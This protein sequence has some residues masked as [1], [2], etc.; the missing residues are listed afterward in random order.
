[1]TNDPY[2]LPDPVATA[3]IY[4]ADRLDHVI[5]HCVAPFW[6]AV[7]ERDG[8]EHAYLWMMRYRRGGEH[9]KVRIHAPDPMGPVLRTELEQAARSYLDTLEGAATDGRDS[10][11]PAVPPVDVEDEVTEPYPDRS[12]LWTRYRRSPVSFGAE[13][14]L[15][16][17]RFAAIFTRAMSHG[18]ARVMAAMRADDGAKVPF[19]ARQAAVLKAV[20]SGLSAVD[21]D[22]AMRASYLS[23]HRD[24]LLRYMT[25]RMH[26]GREHADA[27]LARFTSIME[28]MGPVLRAVEQTIA[29]QWSP[30]HGDA[31]RPS[32]DWAGSL[33][34]LADHVSRSVCYAGQVIDPFACDPAFPALFKVIH[35]LANQAGFKALDES[36]VYHMLLQLYAPGT[37]AGFAVE[38][39]GLADE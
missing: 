13:I 26:G 5:D 8:G 11:D 4:C 33:R 34:D 29:A 28:K 20:I 6:R 14:F 30:A 12:F 23:Y 24:W 16:N 31:R 39:R 27:L 35:G 15:A 18:S 32:G 36:F 2:S 21:W 38:P 3:S 37:D 7:T 1:M 10:A 17:D 25:A 9:L 22:Q 19:R